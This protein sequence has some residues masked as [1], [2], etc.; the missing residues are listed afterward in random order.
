[1][2]GDQV[3]LLG[4]S[5]ESQQARN[6]V[7]QHDRDMLGLLTQGKPE[8]MVAAM[9][10]QQNPTRWSSTGPIVAGMGIVGPSTARVLHYQGAIDQNGHMLVSMV[11]GVI[12]LA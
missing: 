6:R 11:A 3:Q 4:D 5:A 10:W 2:F 12:E 8:E 7:V 1:M 9:A